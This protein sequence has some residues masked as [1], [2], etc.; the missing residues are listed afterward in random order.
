MYGPKINIRVRHTMNTASIISYLLSTGTQKQSTLSLRMSFQY[1]Q[2]FH[3][4]F[5]HI[6]THQDQDHQQQE[7]Y[8][9]AH[10]NT[11]VTNDTTAMRAIATA[12][13]PAV[14][15]TL[16]FIGPPSNLDMLCHQKRQS[17]IMIKCVQNCLSRLGMEVVLS[18]CRA[19]DWPLIM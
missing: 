15:Y 11:P 9:V 13:M 10:Y 6:S 3:Y 5:Y 16:F 2:S 18:N 14:K 17:H 8:K 19:L 7:L 12:K 4:S 1:P